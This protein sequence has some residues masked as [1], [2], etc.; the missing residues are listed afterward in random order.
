MGNFDSRFGVG[1]GQNFIAED[2]QLVTQ[3]L[4]KLAVLVDDQNAALHQIQCSTRRCSGSCRLAQ[5]TNRKLITY[6][7]VDSA[8]DYRS[9]ING[10]SEINGCE[11]FYKHCIPTGFPDRLL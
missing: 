7:P 4:R 10:L 5:A 9:P 2:P 8:T 3:S 1:G 11:L 6:L